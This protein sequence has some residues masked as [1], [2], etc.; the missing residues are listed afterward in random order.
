MLATPL[1]KS[2]TFFMDVWIRIQSA[3]ILAIQNSACSLYVQYENAQNSAEL[4]EILY[5]NLHGISRYPAEF[6]NFWCNGIPHQGV[7]FTF[8]HLLE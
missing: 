5:A 6:R 4:S 8:L 2:P 3:S 1:L 7:K